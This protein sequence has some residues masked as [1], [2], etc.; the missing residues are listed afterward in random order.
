M[1][2]YFAQPQVDLF[3]G[4]QDP[5]TVPP[6]VNPEVARRTANLGA[7]AR[8]GSLDQTYGIFEAL[9][10]ET[11]ALMSQ[12]EA[13]GEDSVR[14]EIAAE[15]QA[16]QADAL[17]GVLRESIEYGDPELTVGS[18]QAYA[19]LTQLDAAAEAKY[20]LERQAVENIQ[21]LA[22]S[23]NIT[24]ARVMLQNLERGNALD[25][26][27]D[28]AAKQQILET[29]LARAQVD[30]RDQ[31]WLRHVA[32]FVLSA[33]PLYSASRTGNVPVQETVKR[34]YDSL[35][36]GQ[37]Y[38]AEADALWD[39]PMED[40]AEFVSGDFVNNL[41]ENATLLG[42]TNNT[43]KLELL[44]GLVERTPE[45]WETNAWAGL[46]NSWV[47]GFVPW[48]TAFRL[49]GA[50]PSG[51]VRAGARKE[52]AELTARA[53]LDVVQDSPE[54]AAR[55]AMTADQVANNLKVSAVAAEGVPNSVPL[56]MDSVSAL[57][58][59]RALLSELPEL[60]RTF[61]LTEQE[62]T[63]AVKT[64]TDRFERQYGREVKDVQVAGESLS[65][66]S[67]VNRV[68]FTLGKKNGGGFASEAMANR[69]L[70]SIGESGTAI[71]DESGQWFA[72][73]THDIPETGFFT[74]LLNVK[75][76][77]PWRFFL[78][79]RNVGD[80]E[81]SNAAMVAGNKRNK[82]LKTLVE[83]YQNTFRALRGGEREALGQVMQAGENMG[84]WFNED[85]LAQL[86][87]RRWNRAPTQRELDAYQA[88]RDVNDIE[89]VLRNDTI[90]KERAI[91]GFRSVT[92]DT[93]RGQVDRA[94]ALIDAELKD[95]VNFRVYDASTG[96]HMVNG[97]PAN[98]LARL[99]AQGYRLVTLEGPMQLSDGTRVR[100]FLVKSKDLVNENL[101]RD[102]IA[103]RPGGHRMYEGQYFVKQTVR[104]V[105]PDT[106]KEFL[107]NPN[108]YIAAV[109]KAEAEFWARRM[110]AARLAL[111][112]GADLAVI[113]EILGGHAGL[114][115]AED[116]VRTMNDPNGAFQKDTKFGVYFDREMPEEYIL[117]ADAAQFVDF[118]DTGL[119]GLLRTQGR[120]YTGRKGEALPDYMGEMAPTLDPFET[121]D[122]SLM[123]IASLSSFNDF[124]IQS[125]ERWM[126]TFGSYLDISKDDPLN[127]A[128]D[129][130]KFMEAK[131]KTGGND[132]MSRI[133]NAGLAQRQIIMRT[134]GWKTENDLRSD[135]WLR[136]MGEWVQ[137]SRV[138]GILPN[139]RKWVYTNWV[140]DTNPISALRSFAFD[141]KLGLF[142]FAQLPLQLSTAAAA[143]M[144]SPKRGMQ[145][146]ALAGPMRFLLGGRSL[147]REAFESRMDELVKRGVHTIGGFDDAKEFKEYA[148]AAVR[149]GFF[150]LGGT[151]GLMDHYGPHAALN[152]FAS[153]V[154]RVREAGRFFFF[155][156]ERLNRLVAWR[157]AWDEA[158]E[159][160]LKP[161]T[162]EFA[163]K[164]QGRA[165]EYSFNMS[166]ESQAWWQKGALS[167][168]TQFWA[169]NARMMEAMT[170]GNFTPAQKARLIVL[171]TLLYGSAGLP[172]VGFFS[173]LAKNNNGKAPD[174]DTIY[175]T[176]DRGLLDR[177]IY[178]MTGADVLVGERYGTGGWLTDT[179]KTLFGASQY[180]EISAADIVGG[181]TYSILG[182]L[183]T[184]LLKPIIEYAA[185]ES[186]DT[187]SPIRRQNLEKLASNI[188][189]IGNVLRARMVW[190]YGIYRSS[191]GTTQVTDLPSQTAVAVL[192]GIQP[193]EMD[194]LSAKRAFT[195]NESKQVA[196]A[197]R[198]I[199]NYRTD[200]LNMPDQA[201]SIAQEVNT[202]VRLLPPSIR[203]K[204]LERAD[205]QV[206][207]SLYQ[208]L[209][210]RY[211]RQQAERERAN[212]LTD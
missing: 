4:V 142:N 107:D 10:A 16:A 101:R 170:V 93:G 151:H 69:Y 71:Q 100:H 152:G 197:A 193:G 111:L 30:V 47:L 181:A 165:E 157:I 162:P 131:F 127:G 15:R 150:D 112:D 190:E 124:K 114:P 94:N 90:Y 159:A 78:N 61:R 33:V 19:N 1:I 25:V 43:E 27:R 20:A 35:F 39:M 125:V 154:E 147:S 121:I 119:N 29:A 171:Q 128:S 189:T 184:D 79:A 22:A 160:G 138:N 88:A 36:A 211:E 45:A 37:R 129:L 55:S 144:L 8:L 130:R 158:V 66:G 200:M 179:V 199:S 143:V 9:D 204:A 168:P 155:E 141:L 72:R 194:D 174:I 65:D 146:V 183:G 187:G 11:E 163:A 53:A 133:R 24:Q 59:G 185:A 44:S 210:E 60:E 21:N 76:P 139:A 3:A 67:N 13:L 86:Y 98:K 206:D 110:E 115:S 120:M 85:Q 102:Q 202:F 209:V 113:D 50:I 123:N 153:G 28:Y 208:S 172:I 212:G 201:E 81:V 122:K 74:N 49:G 99:R 31:S 105:Q 40:F 26:M 6:K 106:G 173:E 116:F 177:F 109:T 75:T 169:Y 92:F 56:A 82:L 96:Q 87:Q 32:D 164:L 148:R 62:L 18:A 52:A 97:I 166:R 63:K 192:F 73:V 132:E 145:G 108:T 149:S 51:M 57:E 167:I 34:W 176:A 41:H 205:G 68:T 89:Y 191:T 14:R 186:G 137:G 134:L 161:N 70:G 104:G 54:A 156:A 135:Q 182:K 64:V 126:K 48:K 84:R 77:G 178:E 175:G 207:P 12:V 17:V 195:S 203:R 91:K 196:D 188:S 80:I 180:G 95:K 117:S 38:R 7:V 2:D 58:R 23:G 46:D 198:V 136:H 103:Y 140:R 83:P 118:E 42:Y 5:A